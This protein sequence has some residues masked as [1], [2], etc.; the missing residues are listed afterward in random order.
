MAYRSD[1]EALEARFQVLETE[2]AQRV[3]ER[4]DAARM[5]DEARRRAH[6]DQIAADLAAGGP[7]RRRRKRVLVAATSALVSLFAAAA[8]HL[9][10]RAHGRIED[11]MLTKLAFY[12]DEMC[13]CTDKSCAEH[14]SEDMMRWGQQIER[15][16]RS[17]HLDDRMERRA[18]ELGR[19]LGE[20]MKTA[21]GA[22]AD[23]APAP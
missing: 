9:A 1:V 19:Q 16:A 14:V 18:T 17:V 10:T 5:L 20:C 15:K 4:D 2:L 8:I 11:E 3:R 22:Q 23:A 21:M 6:A 7:A 12:T 13:T